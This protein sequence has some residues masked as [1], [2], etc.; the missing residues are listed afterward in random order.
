MTD[1][2]QF[3]LFDQAKADNTA[4]GHQSTTPL[5]H[6]LR[7]N[8][9][10]GYFGQEKIVSKLKQKLQTKLTH[11]VL[12]GPPGCGKTTLAHILAKESGF[13]L[14]PFN[15]VLG[16]V[17]ELRKLIDAARE[18]EKYHQKKSII[19][20]DEVHRFN[21]GQQDA[22]LPF[23]ESGEFIFI[24]ATTEYPQTSLN[25]AIIS[26]VNLVEL[27]KLSSDDLLNIIERASEKENYKLSME[28]T[29]LICSISNGDARIA[30]NTLETIIHSYSDQEEI[31]FEELKTELIANSRH[32]DKNSNRHYD[33]I[34]AFIKSVRGSD[35]D[36]ALLWLAIMLDGGEDPV[37]IARRLMILAS[38]DV[39]NANPNALTM[40]NAA[41]YTVQNIGMP[42][43]R[44]T[45]AQATTY[46][47]SSPK[48]NAAYKAI[49]SA[50]DY[51]RST[52]TIDVP[53]HLQSYSVEKKNYQYP[54]AFPGHYVKQ[55]YRMP[56]E[57][58]R[59]FYIPTE[60]GFEKNFKNYLDQL[61]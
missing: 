39:G 32:Y 3:G 45:L 43:A 16:G 21:K 35:P 14:Y 49:D 12:W 51:V 22:L 15:A 37:F 48:S 36:A 10:A 8:D 41:H 52:S 34:S 47:A 33:V 54:H 42:E 30:L 23:L 40:A 53:A 4:R 60:Q 11:I 5:A 1:K 27:G 24:G 38:E 25:R 2:T 6:K 17:K 31:N 29:D 28:V 26:R 56:K 20:I 19:F 13:E 57:Q 50:L 7:P 59:K 46:L 55:H 9:F 44:I 18:M 61:N 58:S